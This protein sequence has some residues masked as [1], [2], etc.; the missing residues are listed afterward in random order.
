[1]PT[2]VQPVLANTHISTSFGQLLEPGL[3][4]IFFETYKAIPE[5]YSKIYNMLNSTKAVEREW[6]MGALSDWTERTS[7]LSEVSYAKVSPG[8][9]RTYTHKA[10]TRGFMV[11]RELF[12]D[13]QY[14]QIEK[15]PK[16]LARAGKAHVEK[17]AML[18][19][20]N[21]FSKDVGGVGASAIYDGQP[22]FSAVHPLVDHATK[23][24][25]NLATGALTSAN[26]QKAILQMR[27]T[28]DEAGNLVVFTP[29][30]LVVPPALEYTAR[31]I[32][33]STAIPGS[34]NNDINV[35]K[36]ALELVVLDYLGTVNGGSDTAWFLQDG[37]NH[38]LNFFWRMKPEFKWD[39]DFDTFV[40][41][42][43]GYMRFSM[44]VSDFRGLIGS[45][46]L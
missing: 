38:E 35:V 42:Y 7:E 39:E 16:A 43:R 17:M 14:N 27:N 31:V 37:T 23:K 44:G 33:E 26:L 3:R 5:Q 12:D 40:A 25:S 36:G 34:A 41:K 18:P 6:G 24:C 13:D 15:M 29:T 45:T 46:G 20:I 2:P 11:G 21:G 30:R 32:L 19:L 9:A 10:F 4:R 22:L 28:V 8:L 1:M